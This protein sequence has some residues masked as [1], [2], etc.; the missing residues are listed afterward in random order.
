MCRLWAG[1]TGWAGKRGL[2]EE[3]NKLTAE[4]EKADLRASGSK[5]DGPLVLWVSS[6]LFPDALTGNGG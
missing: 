2:G 3:I 5:E 4:A 6:S 1:A